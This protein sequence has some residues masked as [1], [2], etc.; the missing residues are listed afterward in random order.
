MRRP[1][2]EAESTFA[3]AP[4]TTA[5]SI[6]GLV[7]K[8]THGKRGGLPTT[9]SA[10]LFLV[11]LRVLSLADSQSKVILPQRQGQHFGVEPHVLLTEAYTRTRE[12]HVA[13]V[14]CVAAC[15]DDESWIEHTTHLQIKCQTYQTLVTHVK[16]DTPVCRERASVNA[17]T[18]CLRVERV[19]LLVFHIGMKPILP[20]VS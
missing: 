6:Y 17:P 11:S 10:R 9:P 20:H 8:I 18:G 2:P 1:Q 15:G 16:I 5:L 13:D 7:Q 19:P 12:P 14:R 3:Q 4:A